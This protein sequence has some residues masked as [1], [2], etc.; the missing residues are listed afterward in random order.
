MVGISAALSLDTCWFRMPTRC[1][2]TRPQ[3]VRF[4]PGGLHGDRS[5]L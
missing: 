2:R 5:M 4:R 1:A 3:N